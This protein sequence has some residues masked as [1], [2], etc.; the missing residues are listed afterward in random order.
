MKK[1]WDV[2]TRELFVDP[3]QNP[4]Y[5]ATML[6]GRYEDIRRYLRLHDKRTR[7]FREATGHL[8]AF[9]YMWDL[10]L[11][12]CRGRFIPSDCVT[13]DELFSSRRDAWHSVQRVQSWFHQIRESCFLWSDSH[14]GAFWQTP[15]G[16]S[17]LLLR[18]GFHLATLPSRP[19]C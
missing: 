15:S 3:L 19:D 6:V 13:V 18:S 10:S 7:V 9:W 2:S 8:E 1:R 11:A 17:C 12:N 14:L 16:L 5:K 4:M